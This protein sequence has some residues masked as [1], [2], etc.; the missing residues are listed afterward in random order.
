M[1]MQYRVEQIHGS[2]PWDSQ[3]GQM[4]GWQLGVTNLTT[5]AKQFVEINSKQSSAPYAVGQMFWAD[6]QSERAGVPKLKR[7]KPP[8]PGAYQ[9][10]PQQQAQPVQGVGSAPP[11]WD[12]ATQNRPPAPSRITP[13]H[14]ERAIPYAKAVAVYSRMTQDMNVDTHATTLFLAWLRGDIADPE[15]AAGG[16]APPE[17]PPWQ[18]HPDD[19]GSGVP[20]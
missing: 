11:A 1:A 14:I 18:T 15:P 20:F 5:D 4:I 19:D 17:I 9:P 3:Y 6:V 16:A 8:D 10:A 13:Q 2:S 12:R 7:I